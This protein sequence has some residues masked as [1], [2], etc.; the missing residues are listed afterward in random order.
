VVKNELLILSNMNGTNRYRY[1]IPY[2]TSFERVNYRD[3]RRRVTWTEI[4]ISFYLDNNH[5]YDNKSVQDRAFSEAID[6]AFHALE[7]ELNEIDENIR[8]IMG[9]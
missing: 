8:R 1:T 7:V 6:E 2:L 4:H 5:L 9:A 3:L